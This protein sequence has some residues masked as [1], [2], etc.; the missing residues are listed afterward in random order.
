MIKVEFSERIA[1]GNA[2]AG[3]PAVNQLRINNGPSLCVN[4]ETT[5]PA[6]GA[7]LVANTCYFIT[8]V[9]GKTTLWAKAAAGLNIGD[10]VSASGFSTVATATSASRVAAATSATVVA[11]TALTG[12]ISGAVAG[13]TT[14]TVTFSKPVTTP[15]AANVTVNRSGVITPL[16]TFAFAAGGL[17]EDIGLALTATPATALQA[18]DIVTVAINAVVAQ[19]GSGL[20]API[21]L[22]V[23]LAGPRPTVT[24]A[25]GTVAEVG[26]TLVTTPTVVDTAVSITATSARPAAGAGSISV[27]MNQSAV[28]S[29]ATS[30]VVATD[31]ITGVT[32]ITVTLGTNA[33]AAPNATPAV[34]AAAINAAASTIVT[35]AAANPS[36]TT[37]VP[38]FPAASIPAGTRTLSVVISLSKP[39]QALAA[40]A[41][42]AGLGYDANGDGFSQAT[43]V[44]STAVLLNGTSVTAT[45][46][47]DV[48]VNAV[49]APVAGTSRLRVNAGLF[50]DLNNQ[51]NLAQ[52]IAFS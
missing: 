50:T 29:T 10:H 37:V 11:T 26:G 6:A 20:A 9:D 32:T 39:I 19:S 23:P 31:A 21:S 27:V 46:N 52:A 8:G 1:A 42:I 2:A 25:V 7:S 45:F 34:V 35:A 33:A 40:D 24:S 15:V 38:A 51:T 36:S 14:F 30:A 28:A 5:L 49:A 16:G 48:G 12:A 44:S 41:V 13:A 3:P 47:L 18:G 22:V 4:N 17:A 43:A